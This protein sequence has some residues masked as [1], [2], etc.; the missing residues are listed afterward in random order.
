MIYLALT[1][2]WF[3]LYMSGFILFVHVWLNWVFR[4]LFQEG[5]FPSNWCCADKA[6]NPEGPMSSLLSGF[7]PISI[8]PVLSKMF[9]RLISVHFGRFVERAGVFPEHQ[10]SFRKGLDTC[11]ALLD[12]I[13]AGQATLDSGSE[14]ALI[15]IDFSA[16]FNCVSH[17]SLVLNCKLLEF[18]VRSSV[19]FVAFCLTVSRVLKSI[20]SVVVWT[21]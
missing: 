5:L 10:Y 8:T 16:A 18:V 7:R 11:D 9:E 19:L 2:N 3:N 1:E 6:P 21:M 13:C 17:S 15:Q 4:R 20:V 12:I 14:F